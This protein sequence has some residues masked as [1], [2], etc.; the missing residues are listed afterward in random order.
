M[1]QYLRRILR[2]IVLLTAFFPLTSTTT[3]AEDAGTLM[4]IPSA[5]AGA[6][7]PMFVHATEGAKATV[8]LLPGGGGGIGKVSDNGWP[9]SGNFLVRSAQLFA[10]SGFNVA[11]MARASDMSD[12]DYSVRVGKEH[13]DDIRRVLQMTKQRF[14]GPVWLVGT[15][16]GTVSA[17]AAGIALR[18][19]KLIDGIVLTSSVTNYKKTGAVP[20]Q[21]LDRL[22]VPVLVMHHEK[23][24]CNVCRPYEAP[25]IPKGLKNAP[26]KKLVMVNGGSNPK[27]D[28]CET[29][30]YH[31]YIGMEKEAVGIIVAWIKNPTN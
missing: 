5:R 27:G 10:G 17:A 29:Q 4:R 18:D 28:P 3:F 16:R 22:T 12:L 20:S 2:V 21:D 15:S 19:E 25:A 31:G 26:F 11:I 30:H 8:I 6:E 9:D 1:D 13:I 14:A 23:D 24:A 7:I